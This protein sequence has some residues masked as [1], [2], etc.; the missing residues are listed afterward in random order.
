MTEAEARC[1]VPSVANGYPVLLIPG[2]DTLVEWMD[3]RV[4][5]YTTSVSATPEADAILKATFEGTIQ[6]IP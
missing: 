5:C 6:P 2:Y 3:G 4:R 1:A